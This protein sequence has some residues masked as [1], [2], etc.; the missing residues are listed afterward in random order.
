MKSTLPKPKKTKYKN[1]KT[2]V[3]G[4][5]FD[6]KMESDY[7]LYLLERKEVGEVTDIRLQPVYLLQPSF[8]KHMR[9][10]RKVEYKADFF[11]RYADGTEKVIDVKGVLTPVFKLKCKLFDYYHPDLELLL[12]TKHKGK[13]ILLKDKP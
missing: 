1:K 11:V 3:D 8:K 2:V 7:Y 6:S 9:T 4:I 12:V 5:T 10:I 13:W